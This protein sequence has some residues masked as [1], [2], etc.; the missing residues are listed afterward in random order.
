M[1]WETAVD[2]QRP[3]LKIQINSIEIE[4]FDTGAD[5]MIILP[6]FWHELASSG[7]KYSASRD[8]N[9]I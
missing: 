8:W 1:F 6:E 4:G 5:V 2:D 9:F 3:K 7:G